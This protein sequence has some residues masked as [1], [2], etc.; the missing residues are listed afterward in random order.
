MSGYEYDEEFRAAQRF[1][2]TDYHSEYAARKSRRERVS[3]ALQDQKTEARAAQDRADAAYRRPLSDRDIQIYDQFNRVMG[4]SNAANSREIR[5]LDT[6]KRNMDEALKYSHEE[7]MEKLSDEAYK[8]NG[9][10][11]PKYKGN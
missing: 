7:Y 5:R 9:F 6:R 4:D 8:L 3:S 10:V 11:S 1:Q 2:T